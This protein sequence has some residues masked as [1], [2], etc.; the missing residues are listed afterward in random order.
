M[1]DSYVIVA[2]HDGVVDLGGFVETADQHN[3]LSALVEATEGVRGVD[4]KVVVGGSGGNVHSRPPCTGDCARVSDQHRVGVG[5]CKTTRR[6]RTQDLRHVTLAA[7]VPP[8]VVALHGRNVGLADIGAA[9]NNPWA[10]LQGQGPKAPA[11]DDKPAAAVGQPSVGA[12]SVRPN[13]GTQASAG[14]Q[15]PVAAAALRGIRVAACGALV[16]G[17]K[18]LS[19][20]NSRGR[21]FSVIVVASVTL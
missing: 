16:S 5:V 12:S 15:Q 9:A 6:K 19:L 11:D 14:S 20:I 10:L 18:R 13:G 2:V 1:N 17:A 7:T 3:A 8:I 21:N 4:D